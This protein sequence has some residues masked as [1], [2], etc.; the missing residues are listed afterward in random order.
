MLRG[1]GILLFV[2]TVSG[3][4]ARFESTSAQPVTPVEWVRT[5]DGWE[6]T[7]VLSAPDQSSGA[8]LHPL[9]VGGF[10]LAA[11]QHLPPAVAAS[12]AGKTPSPNAFSDS[13]DFLVRIRPARDTNNTDGVLCC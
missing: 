3:V 11:R 9:L 4:L 2:V 1:I 10:Q 5:V 6:P 13:S 12:A 8:V 7:G